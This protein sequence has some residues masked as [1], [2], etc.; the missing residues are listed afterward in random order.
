MAELQK[1]QLVNVS[2]SNF[3]LMQFLMNLPG[4]LIWLTGLAFFLFFKEGQSLRVL[5]YTYLAVIFIFIL[6]RGKH[7]YTLGIYPVLFAAGGV[8]LERLFATHRRWIRPAILALMIVV[9]LP[10]IPYSL[11]ILPHE[12]MLVYAEKSKNFGL[13]NALRWE[14]GRI[15][16]LPQDYADMIGWEELANVVIKTYHSLSDA[17]KG[18]CVIYAE[19]YGQA[20]AIKYYGKKHGL[21]EPASFN[22]TFLFWAP[23]SVDFTT[24]IYVND[25]VDEISY[26][27]GE[28]QKAGEITN[29]FARETGLPVYLCRHPRSDFFEF[30]REKVREL[31]N[32]FRS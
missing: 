18:R 12:R 3:V 27:F 24:L 31:K 10:V 4:L 32:G 28:V 14:D 20:G 9:A 19:N 17:E 6:F 22:E 8:L 2:I 21:P 11:P 26:F 29:P 15:H 1:T 5:G 16:P 30:Y 7:Y 25:E 23:D 13:E